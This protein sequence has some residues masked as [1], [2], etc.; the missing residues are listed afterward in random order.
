MVSFSVAQ[1]TF[2]LH[3]L[4]AASA[5]LSNRMVVRRKGNATLTG[6]SCAEKHVRLYINGIHK[7]W[8]NLT[9]SFQ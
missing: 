2:G 3:L 5:S 6:L 1:V 8:L 9:E 4:A 7:Y